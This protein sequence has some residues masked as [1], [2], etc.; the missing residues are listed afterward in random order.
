M[1]LTERRRLVGIIQR[2]LDMAYAGPVR[3]D[4]CGRTDDDWWDRDLIHEAKAVIAISEEEAW[5][6]CMPEK[7]RWEA[8]KPFT[9]ADV[10]HT[11]GLESYVLERWLDGAMRCDRRC[12]SPS[13][14]RI[15][16]Q[17][18]DWVEEMLALAVKVK[19][20]EAGDA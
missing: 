17:V 20:W 18:L 15:V 5:R 12:D 19:G 1:R 9:V 8:S 4:G 3:C 14:T 11:L 10:I 13:P 16:E 2:L 7:E 6:P